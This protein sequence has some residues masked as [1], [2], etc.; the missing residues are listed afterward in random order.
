MSGC[1]ELSLD[2]HKQTHIRFKVLTQ[3]K[4]VLESLTC[5]Y[6]GTSDFRSLSNAFDPASAVK[7][8]GVHID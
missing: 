5:L 7:Y 6:G 1:E 4:L 3:P 8:S 2:C